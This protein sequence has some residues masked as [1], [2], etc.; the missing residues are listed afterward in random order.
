M[1]FSR[2]IA[3]A[4]WLCDCTSEHHLYSF[5]VKALTPP[6][7]MHGREQRGRQSSCTCDGKRRKQV[8]TEHSIQTTTTKTKRNRER[9]RRK[10][11]A[12]DAA[13]IKERSETTRE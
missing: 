7:E 10:E 1:D 4:A 3:V 12:D 9:E 11:T 2:L 13:G 8:H 5:T 6:H